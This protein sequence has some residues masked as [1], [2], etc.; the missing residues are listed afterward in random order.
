MYQPVPKIDIGTKN[1]STEIRHQYQEQTLVPRIDSG[2][3]N[4]YLEQTLVL[5]PDI[6][7]GTDITS[8]FPV[9][10][11]GTEIRPTTN[12]K[13]LIQLGYYACSSYNI[14]YCD[15]SKQLTIY[16]CEGDGNEGV[17]RD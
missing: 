4:R 15:L 5:R 2:T 16:V 8:H 17:G 7:I 9:L 11:G 14:T 3:K 1:Y 13:Q 10:T 6:G 12:L